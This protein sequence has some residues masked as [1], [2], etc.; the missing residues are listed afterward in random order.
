MLI[1]SLISLICRWESYDGEK[2][3]LIEDVDTSMEWMGSFLKIWADRYGFR[4]EIKN[5]S[6]VLRPEKIFVTSNYHPKDIFKD[7]SVLLAILDRFNIVEVL[8]MKDYD[9]TR[10]E[11]PKKKRKLV[12]TQEQLYPVIP[13]L[14]T[15]E[16]RERRKKSPFNSA[17]EG[18]KETQEIVISE[19]E[20]EIVETNSPKD[21]HDEDCLCERCI[22]F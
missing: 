13:D 14:N 21:F 17:Y 10:P 11:E 6:A 19:E 5:D 20:M 9:D 16:D 22:D 18:L 8:K 4:A 1:H 3:V 12:R 15:D 2:N 7:Q